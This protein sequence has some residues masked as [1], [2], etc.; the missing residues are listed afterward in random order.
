MMLLVLL[1]LLLLAFG[2]QAYSPLA[3][4]QKLS[5]GR[6][7]ALA[8]KHGKTPAQVIFLEQSSR[9]RHIVSTWAATN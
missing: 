5:D 1:L 4:A 8:N 6:V 7:V 9:V 3:K 2:V